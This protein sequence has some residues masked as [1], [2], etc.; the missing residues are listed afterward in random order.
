MTN[1]VKQ[2]VLQSHKEMLA[3]LEKSGIDYDL[4][5][6]WE[7][8]GERSEEAEKLARE[9]ADLDW[10]LYGDALGLDFGGDGDNGE[11]LIDLINILFELRK[12][13]ER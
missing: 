1:I 3:R 11:F 13:E 12:I 9:I 10:L 8:G 6:K 4:T 5:A 2:P 7:R